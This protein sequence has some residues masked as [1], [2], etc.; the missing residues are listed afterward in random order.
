MPHP[1]RRAF[2]VVLNGEVGLTFGR[3]DVA[4]VAAA[5]DRVDGGSAHRP[6][7]SEGMRPPNPIESDHR[8]RTRAATL[9]IG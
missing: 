1:R 7:K 6:S 9:L 5:P 4:A 3:V 2:I 8:I